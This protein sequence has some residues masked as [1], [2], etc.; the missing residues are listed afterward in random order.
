MVADGANGRDFNRVLSESTIDLC[1][2]SVVLKSSIV[3]RLLITAMMDCVEIN[4]LRCPFK[5]VNIL[6][7]SSIQLR[8]S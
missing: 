2:A 5:K 8:Q 6:K 7:S 4:K 1:K 3:V